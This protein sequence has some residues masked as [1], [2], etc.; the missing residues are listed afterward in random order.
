MQARQEEAYV[1]S[2]IEANLR[3]N[4]KKDDKRGLCGTGQ[5]KEEKDAPLSLSEEKVFGEAETAALRMMQTAEEVKQK[6]KGEVKWGNSFKSEVCVFVYGTEIL[7]L[8]CLQRM[9]VKRGG[10]K[11]L[12]V[13]A[14]FYDTMHG[15]VSLCQCSFKRKNKTV[16][17]IV[18]I[19]ASVQ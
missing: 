10:I 19:I 13:R 9:L 14:S 3:Q 16:G 5:K 17:F 8:V 6:A 7:F 11:S 12:F 15:L 4:W 18:A 2:Q 1:K